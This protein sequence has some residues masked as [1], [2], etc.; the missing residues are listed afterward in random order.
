M[1]ILRLD[2]STEGIRQWNV[3]SETERAPG[4]TLITENVTFINSK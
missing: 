2:W 3:T 1:S 4:K